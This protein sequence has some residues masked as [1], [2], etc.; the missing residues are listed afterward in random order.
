M[1]Q[2]PRVLLLS[3]PWTSL[4]E[5]SLGLAILKAKLK[6]A[7]I[8]CTIRHLNIFLLKYIKP[9]SYD[10]TGAL[11]AF[12][13]FLFTN[14]LQ[15][16]EV[17]EEQLASLVE[18]IK[19]TYGRIDLR[20]RASLDSSSYVDYALRMRNEIIPKYLDDCMQAVEE[21]DPSMVGFTCM[22]DQTFPSLAMAR[23]IKQRYP[24]KLVVF[25]GYAIEKPIGD[26]VLRSFPFV[27]VIAFGE[28]EEK[29]VPLAEAS[30]DRNRLAAI[31][32]I[33]FREQASIRSTPPAAKLDLDNSP[34]PDYDDWFADAARLDR[35]H[36]VRIDT[37]C[38]PVESSRGCWWGEV[39]H[40]IFCG[41]D[42]ETMRYRYKS[43]HVV[44]QMLSTLHERYGFKNFRFSDYILPRS[45]Y[46]TLLPLLAQGPN[47]Y[48]LHC[49]M[50]SN[51]RKEEVSA[52]A[53]AG[54]ERVQTGIESFS[55]P[56]LSRMRKGVTGI[57]NV[58]TIKHLMAND[59]RVF[60][61][62]IY[63]FPNE[64]PAEYRRLC[65]DL[66]LLYHLSPPT[67]YVS[68]LTTRYAPLHL[69]PAAFGITGPIQAA[70]RYEMIL[71]RKYRD[72]AGFD[73]NNYC[74]VFETPYKA[75]EELQK[76]YDILLYQL[77]HWLQ[78]FNSRRVELSYQVT[79]DGIEFKDS[80]FHAE[81]IVF[82]LSSDHAAAHEAIA[83]KALT[84]AQLA[85]ELS[86]RL[87]AAGVDRVLED[88]A[89]ARLIYQEGEK[90][91]ALAF[92]AACYDRWAK[93]RTPEMQTVGA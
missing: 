85:A 45:Y 88:L 28:G 19:S 43:P 80:R 37:L 68:V 1:P 33:M 27:D 21:A 44:T 53:G 51:V 74:Y 86:N 13:D 46:K 4:Q 26:Q 78:L 83:E 76:L 34:T 62:I 30:I 5:P 14:A 35:E 89:E 54:F 20:A 24:E 93:R 39:S 87:T 29:I 61:N 73:V 38:L 17:D 48:S 79:A 31:P 67:S 60:Y 18:F 55:S 49:E 75:S 81:G 23:L 59:I 16:S 9:D 3:L 52:M 6:G 56:V 32:G 63:G 66:P 70:P 92:P 65:A 50:K 41:I 90:V 77:A 47:R 64:D 36:Q 91:L 71:S 11:Y 7:G 40:C 69:D 58:L 22:Y 84:R 2:A 8:A 25:G 42:D 15:E 57:Q 82:R 12:N 72:D 10:S